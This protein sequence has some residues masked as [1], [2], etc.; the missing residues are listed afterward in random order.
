MDFDGSGRL[1]L[2]SG[3]NCCDS[4]GFHLFRRLADGSFGP[5]ER[6]E[7]S[8]AGK[9]RLPNLF[10]ESLVTVADWNG[11][12]VPDLL[13]SHYTK[14]VVALGPFKD[15]E[16]IA[17]TYEIEIDTERKGPTQD[18]AVADWN[19][20]GKPDLLVLQKQQYRAGGIY[21]YKNLGGPGMTKLAEGKLLLEIPADVHI[22]GFCVGDWNGDGWP[23]LIV[24]REESMRNDPAGSHVGWRTSAWLYLRESR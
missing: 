19:R 5:R 18:F 1:S 4:L 2:L 24:T 7:F 16:A 10:A 11:D 6:L 12:G 21:W 22:H 13:T 23:D 14:I 8:N 3:S 20:D 17:L 9:I 15:R